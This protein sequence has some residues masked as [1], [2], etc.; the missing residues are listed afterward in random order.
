MVIPAYG[1]DVTG[2]NAIWGVRGSMGSAPLNDHVV[3]N[4]SF[5]EPNKMRCLA[6][7]V[8]KT[9]VVVQISD[10]TFTFNSANKVVRYDQENLFMK[11]ENAELKIQNEQAS[12][13][14]GM[15]K[16]WADNDGER[17][18]AYCA[19][20]TSYFIFSCFYW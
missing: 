18:S 16:S 6:K 19:D 7:V 15:M 1:L 11:G 13:G 8:D 2:F 9:G 14:E 4:C 3:T 17:Y 10:C 12:I 20:G 5:P